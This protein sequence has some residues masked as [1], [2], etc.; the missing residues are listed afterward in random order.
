MV[1]VISGAL[2][3]F[4]GY[5]REHELDASTPLIGIKAL[6]EKSPGLKS[7]L[8]DEA[9]ELRKFNMVYI[10]KTRASANTLN[11]QARSDAK[12]EIVTAIA[13]G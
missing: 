9:G 1:I 10:D 4:V 3:K 13:G 2:L 5:Q 7:A 6:A 8:F 12:V 11:L